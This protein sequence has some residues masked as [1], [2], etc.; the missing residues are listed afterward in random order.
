MITISQIIDAIAPELSD[1]DA[2]QR[3]IIID[4]ASMRLS[5]KHFKQ[6]YNQ[7]VALMAAHLM[8]ISK[9]NG[10][11]GSVTSVKEGDLSIGYGNSFQDGKRLDA[12]SYGSEL[13]TLMR[14]RTLGA[15]TAV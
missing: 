5:E 8:T 12:T 15:G 11:S 2:G 1:F 9:R 7:A 4:I 14:E 6:V 13:L 3:Q 10:N